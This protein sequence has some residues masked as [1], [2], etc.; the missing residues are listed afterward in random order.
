MLLQNVPWIYLISFSDRKPRI[1][2][3]SNGAWVEI[4]IFDYVFY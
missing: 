4:M 2:D 3:Y 1:G